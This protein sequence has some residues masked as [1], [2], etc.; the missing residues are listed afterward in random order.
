MSRCALASQLAALGRHVTFC[1]TIYCTCSNPLCA[2]SMS[3]TLGHSADATRVRSTLVKRPP[4]VAILWKPSGHKRL[5]A[6]IADLESRLHHTTMTASE[7]KRCVED[8]GK[9]R[10]AK[11]ATAGADKKGEQAGN[12]EKRVEDLRADIKDCDDELNAIKEEQVGA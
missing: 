5:L 11:K 1:R 12:T 3:G 7:E 4:F 2:D 6:Q 10:K 8:I 9:L